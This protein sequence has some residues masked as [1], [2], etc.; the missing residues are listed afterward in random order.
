MLARRN[1]MIALED[2]IISPES[3]NILSKYPSFLK[4][5]EAVD[6]LCGSLRPV[7][8]GKVKPEQL[9]LIMEIELDRMEEEVHAPVNVLT[10]TADSMPGFGIVA[11]VLGIVITMATISGPIE[12][13]GE[14]GCG[15]A[16]GNF[17]RNIISLWIFE[18]ARRKT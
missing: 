6:F 1:G 8:D 17:S 12:H 16:G 4:N 18:P 13:I 11:A 14:K 5:K 3:S 10:K 7:I 15:S 2:H 9:K